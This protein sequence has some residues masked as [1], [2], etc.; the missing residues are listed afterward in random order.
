MLDFVKNNQYLVG[1]LVAAIGIIPPLL[2]FAISIYNTSQSRKEE[3]S[4]RQYTQYHQL[5]GDLASN[6]KGALD[7][8]TAI[9]Y[10]LRFY[11]KYRHATIRIL[12]NLKNTWGAHREQVLHHF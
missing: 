12:N 7:S 4:N 10:E 3:L 11:R 8:Q 1:L 2:T 5:I 9:V 6:A